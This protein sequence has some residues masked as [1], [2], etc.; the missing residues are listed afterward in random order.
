MSA[1]MM[2]TIVSETSNHMNGECL[3]VTMSEV[4]KLWHQR[5]GHLSYKGLRTLQNK[6]MVR[7]LPEFEA[8][9]ITCVDCL[10]GR[11]TRNA[12]PK[13][14]NWRA[15]IILELIHS[16][17]CGP[18]SPTSNSGK[19]Y[20][21]SFIDDFSRKAWIYLLM[22]KSDAL[23]CFKKFHCMVE[24]ERN[25]SL[26]CLRTDRGGEYTSSAFNEYCRNKGIKRQLTNAYTPQQN[27]V[28]ERKNRIVMNMVRSMLSA[29]KMPKAF[30][31]EAVLW[32]FHIL[33]KCPTLAVK[34]AT[35]QEAWSNVKP[36]V[37]HFKI[38]GCLAHT[39]VPEVKRDKL[40][41]RSSI[42]IFLGYS[43]NTKEE[44][45]DTSSEETLNQ[46]DVI[47]E[48]I[49]EI[50]EEVTPSQGRARRS[51]RAP[52]W[53]SDY[54]LQDDENEEEVNLVQD[55]DVDD[56]VWYE[57]AAKHDKWR[58]AMQS[59]I[60]SIQKNNTWSFTELPRSGKSIEVKWI[61][62]TKRDENGK[63]IKHK[64]RLVAKGYSQKEGIDYT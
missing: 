64:A 55:I 29:K 10:N 33:N 34:N 60:D 11:Q 27:G 50:P 4:A 63:I 21:L 30:W 54:V 12:I 53:M 45:E 18:I 6:K 57:E 3:Q 56:P 37:D 52:A 24:K 43:D 41:K 7:G 47:H 23:D 25:A 62:K 61:Y 20:F 39:H 31:T 38:W 46:E 40:D 1:N 16:D 58:M 36:S 8:E 59:E 9:E 2:F 19:R 26:K 13:Q 22:N 42:C 44:Q 35:P 5:F 32:T 48:E 51:H 28:A 15:S 49:E 14:A 17:I